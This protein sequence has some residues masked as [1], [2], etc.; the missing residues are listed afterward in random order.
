MWTRTAGKILT[1]LLCISV[2]SGSVHAG[3]QYLA[4]TGHW[5]EAVYSPQGIT[6]DTANSNAQSRGGH[7]VTVHSDA[8]NQFIFTLV[9]DSRYWNTDPEHTPWGPWLGGFQLPGAPEPSGGWQWVT[10][11]PFSYT[12]WRPPQPDNAGNGEHHL[13]MYDTIP[14]GS[15]RWNDQP[16]ST[17]LKSYIVEYEPTL[18]QI[19]QTTKTPVSSLITI[20]QPSSDQLHVF[21]GGGN[22]DTTKPTIVLTHGWNSDPEKAFGALADTISVAGTNANIAAW[23][24]QH[25]AN[26]GL[27]LGKAAC[28]VQSQGE[29]MGKTLVDTLGADYDEEIHFIGHSLGTRVNKYAVDRIHGDGLASEKTHV[30]LLDA[31]DFP[32]PVAGSGIPQDAAW[33]DNY[34]SAVGMLQEQAANVILR[35]NMPGELPSGLINMATIVADAAEFHRYS[36]E[37]YEETVNRSYDSDMGFRWSFESGNLNGAH[38]LGSVFAQ[39]TDCDDD[40]LALNQIDWSEGQSIISDRNAMYVGHAGQTAYLGLNALTNPIA[41]VGEVSAEIAEKWLEEGRVWTL[42]LILEEHSPAYAWVPLKIPEGAQYISFDFLFENVGEED[43][44]T[45]GIDEEMLFAIEGEYIVDGE[46]LNSGL[47]DISAYQ[48]QEAELFCGLNSDGIAGGSMTIE[49]IQFTA[50]PEPAT[51]SLLGVGLL[52]FLRRRK[53]ITR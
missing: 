13:H 28:R 29:A 37:W 18:P 27:N 16:G 7:L 2:T 52:G 6:W 10:G 9:N 4:S 19:S 3:Q 39:T 44:L 23:D 43:Y 22:L 5:Y 12:N 53:K 38:S 31:P 30:T 41:A 20:T 14:D 11:E 17:L 34:V 51:I 26:T 1:I 49:G 40:E 35:G 36:V 21:T 33:V 32:I 42:R 45:F 48:G 46:A 8:E 47:L 25:D 24:W 15:G 50:V